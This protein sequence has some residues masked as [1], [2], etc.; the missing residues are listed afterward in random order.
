MKKPICIPASIQD[1]GFVP[2]P[3]I[4]LVIPV[5]VILQSH[6]NLAGAMVF[7]FVA[8]WITLIL[9]LD[10][11]KRRTLSGRGA[12]VSDEGVSA[13][14]EG[15]PVWTLPWSQFGGYRCLKL[16]ERDRI[17]HPE[18]GGIEVLDTKGIPK[19]ILNIE[20]S[21]AVHQAH[22]LPGVMRTL[23]WRALDRHVPPGG[24]KFDVSKMR[25]SPTRWRVAVGGAA[26]VLFFTAC[27]LLIGS[28]VEAQNAAKGDATIYVSPLPLGLAFI[29]FFAASLLLVDCLR[30]ATRIYFPG[31]YERISDGKQVRTSDPVDGPRYEDFLIENGGNLEPVDLENGIRYI[32][33]DPEYRVKRLSYF[34]VI[35]MFFLVMG[36]LIVAIVNLFSDP[37]SRGASIF[38][39]CM[40]SPTIALMA[41]AALDVTTKLRNLRDTIIPMDG[42]LIVIKPN[43]SHISFSPHAKRKLAMNSAN[44]RFETWKEG[45]KK[46]V[47]DRKLLLKASVQLDHEELRDLQQELPN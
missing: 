3:P 13:T 43:G 20:P 8:V 39:I 17:L 41:Y 30:G 21:V 16:S 10:K 15:N 25:F 26:S 42:G 27:P 2:L 35:F 23:F 32:H 33:V 45:N 40:G 44:A 6:P 9:F 12:M 19:G 1:S 11:R 37:A 4:L 34:P 46:Y 29:S 28:F 5:F 36:G 22:L 47:L 31:L 14:M 18:R 38:M 24:S 7:P